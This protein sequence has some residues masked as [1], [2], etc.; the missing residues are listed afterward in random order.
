MKVNWNKLRKNIPERLRAG[1][2]NIFSIIWVD[3]YESPTGVPLAGG[4]NFNPKKEIL[5]N[6]AFNDNEVIHTL[7]HEYLH[8]L[9][10][11]HDMKLTETQVE[12]L[13]ACYPVLREF[14]L[15]LEGKIK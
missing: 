13:E 2:R 8:A 11:V 12:K 1:R 14:V 9:D 6:P 4:T 10:W 5:L 3:H 7:F 15:R